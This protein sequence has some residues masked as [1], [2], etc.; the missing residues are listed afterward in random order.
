MTVIQN[1]DEL[2][3][4]R[5]LIDLVLQEILMELSTANSSKQIQFTSQFLQSSKKLHR[6]LKVPF[7]S[8]YGEKDYQKIAADAQP[9][10][11]KLFLDTHFNSKTSDRVMNEVLQ[12]YSLDK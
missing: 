11:D 4:T 10:I 6:I 2:K 3:S 1:Q 7:I 9:L 8:M 12:Y 5:E